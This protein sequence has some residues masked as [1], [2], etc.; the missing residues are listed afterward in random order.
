M[1]K[2][3]VLKAIIRLIIQDFNKTLSLEEARKIMKDNTDF[4]AYIYND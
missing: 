2:I 1:H 3:L 4:D